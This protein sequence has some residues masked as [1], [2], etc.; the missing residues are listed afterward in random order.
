[1]F[2]QF[3]LILPLRFQVTGLGK[4]LIFKRWIDIIY[5]VDL[6]LLKCQKF[7]SPAII[8]VDLNSVQVRKSYSCAVFFK[9]MFILFQHHSLAFLPRYECER[10]CAHGMPA[11]IIAIFF[12]CF[13]CGNRAILHAENSYNGLKRLLQP[14][15]KSS[16]INCPERFCAVYPVVKDPCARACHTFVH[17]AGKAVQYIRCHQPSSFAVH[18]CRVIMKEYIV[19]E[20][21][22][23]FFIVC[24]K[25][26]GFCQ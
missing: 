13:M 15:H 12:R 16:I 26:P 18:K 20:M 17:D 4:D 3:D 21:K 22:C 25:L 24:G 9:I 10:A 19:P 14:Q 23:N 2:L 8:K 11:K 6:A 1:M 7:C 5:K